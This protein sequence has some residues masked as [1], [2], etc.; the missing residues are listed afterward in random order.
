MWRTKS[1]NLISY[2]VLK[3]CLAKIKWPDHNA[4]N[5]LPPYQISESDGEEPAGEPEKHTRCA[6]CSS[7]VMPMFSFLCH[8]SSFNK[9]GFPISSTVTIS[10]PHRGRRAIRPAMPMLDAH[11]A[12]C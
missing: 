4:Q 12:F 9:L 11:A 5:N 8:V 3:D 2:P 6:S 10:K 1:A 7:S